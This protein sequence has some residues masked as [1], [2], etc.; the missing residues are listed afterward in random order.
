MQVFDE[1]EEQSDIA[2][3]FRIKVRSADISLFIWHLQVNLAYYEDLD[4][5]M[6]EMEFV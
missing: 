2:D 4:I 1:Y 6:H 3:K 5:E